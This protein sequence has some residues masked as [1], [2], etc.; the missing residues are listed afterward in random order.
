MLPGTT[1]RLEDAGCSPPLLPASPEAPLYPYQA[2]EPSLSRRKHLELEYKK[3]VAMLLHGYT[4]RFSPDTPPF[5]GFA[6][7]FND[8]PPVWRV[9]PCCQACT[10]AHHLRD[11][12]IYA[13][14]EERILCLQLQNRS[15]TC[16]WH[17][18]N[19]G[20]ACQEVRF[21]AVCVRR[22]K[23]T[24]EDLVE[25]LHNTALCPHFFTIERAV[26]QK[27]QHFNGAPPGQQERKKQTFIGF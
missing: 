4:K 13:T 27:R 17:R 16:L 20:K 23:K 9:L 3:Q 26:Y 7:S 5:L 21:C 11:C 6:M 25:T 10:G 8:P 2:P 12:M 15:L 1:E 22:R 14:A 24:E 19:R 18:V